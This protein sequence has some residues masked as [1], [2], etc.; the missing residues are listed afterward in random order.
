[1]QRLVADSERM[2]GAL[3]STETARHQQ[4]EV[5]GQG[6]GSDLEVKGHSEEEF[7]N[8]QA[9]LKVASSEL[10][11]HLT[12]VKELKAINDDQADKIRQLQDRYVTMV[13]V[14]TNYMLTIIIIIIIAVG[15][16]GLTTWRGTTHRRE[17]FWMM[18]GDV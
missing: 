4:A 10:S 7:I 11:K 13:T 9:R 6:Q 12:Q 16:I 15:C 5:E 1:V 2:R 3:H 8:V 14:A 18:S 17:H